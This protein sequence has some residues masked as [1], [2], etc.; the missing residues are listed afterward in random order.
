MLN[1][2]ES[3][4]LPAVTNLIPVQV[5]VPG[6]H[7]TSSITDDGTLECSLKDARSQRF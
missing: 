7:V 2:L 5:E 4:K 3:V 6:C 1:F